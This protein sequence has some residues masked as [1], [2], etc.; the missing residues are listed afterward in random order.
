MPLSLGGIIELCIIMYS[1]DKVGHT[2][3]HAVVLRWKPSVARAPN[4]TACAI[5]VKSSGQTPPTT[6]RHETCHSIFSTPRILYMYYCFWY[7]WPWNA[8]SIVLSATLRSR[9]KSDLWVAT[10]IEWLSAHNSCT[11]MTVGMRKWWRCACSAGI[12]IS[13]WASVAEKPPVDCNL[14][15][16]ISG[17]PPPSQPKQKDSKKPP[18]PSQLQPSP[19]DRSSGEGLPPPSDILPPL[20]AS[21]SRKKTRQLSPLQEMEAKFMDEPQTTVYKGNA[22]HLYTMMCR[23]LILYI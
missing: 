18:H 1:K 7:Q 22:L 10:Y 6:A 21:K 14:R 15:P 4:R 3:N 16:P 5:Y 12:V 8:S 9:S 11:V 23:Y 13:C 2:G 20:Q 17:T 19:R